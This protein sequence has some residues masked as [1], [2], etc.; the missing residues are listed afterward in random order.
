M[1]VYACVHLTGGGHSPPPPPPHWSW[2]LVG[3]VVANPQKRSSRHHLLDHL[4]G[5][6]G[7]RLQ[8]YAGW[9]RGM[10]GCSCLRK[11][12]CRLIQETAWQD[13]SSQGRSL[14]CAAW[15]TMGTWRQTHAH[16]RQ[17]IVGPPARRTHAT[18][19]AC[20]TTYV[21]S[22][23]NE[24]RQRPGA[25]PSGDPKTIGTHAT[26]NRDLLTRGRDTGVENSTAQPSTQEI[27]LGNLGSLSQY[28]P[29]PQKNHSQSQDIR[30]H[31][32]RHNRLVG[33]T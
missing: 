19:N 15:R 2:T 21:N 29:P 10:S 9:S 28:P 12:R 23:V 14:G 16:P 3:N 18:T 24:G 5:S 11:R 7:A 33:G 17:R 6:D 1:V 22:K 30:P 26:R 31:G 20:R 4:K 25:P 32:A 27:I 8:Q 13:E